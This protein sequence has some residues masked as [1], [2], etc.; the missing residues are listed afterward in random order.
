[1]LRCARVGV[2]PVLF[3]DSSDVGFDEVVSG[4]DEESSEAEEALVLG[5]GGGEGGRGGSPCCVR[6]RMYA[7]VA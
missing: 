2:G 1:M 5:V 4:L 3:L 6:T 7:S